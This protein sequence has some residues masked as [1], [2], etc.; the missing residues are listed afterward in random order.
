MNEDKSNENQDDNEFD[1]ER[2][3]ETHMHRPE[4]AFEEDDNADDVIPEIEIE[5]P[6]AYPSTAEPSGFEEEPEDDAI[7]AELIE[8]LRDDFEEAPV[9]VDRPATPR[10]VHTAPDSLAPLDDEF[11]HSDPV[12]L[13]HEAAQRKRDG[14]TMMMLGAF[15]G[16]LAVPVLIGSAFA[17][18]DHAMI[19]NIVAGVVLLAIGV[20]MF[21]RGRFVRRT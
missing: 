13:S 5:R 21:L 16:I 9:L 17:G 1:L 19:V 12:V 20:G 6:E 2:R 3:I 15:V 10:A 11:A 8:P 4:D 18:R 7:P 14:E